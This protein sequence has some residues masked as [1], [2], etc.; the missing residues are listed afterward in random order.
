MGKTL[1]VSKHSKLAPYS[2]GHIFLPCNCK[3]IQNTK[4]KDA[5]YPFS[6]LLH[7]STFSVTF[8]PNAAW[9]VFLRHSDLQ[10]KTFSSKT[11]MGHWGQATLRPATL[12]P[13]HWG[14]ATLRPGDIEARRRWGQATLRPGDFEARYVWVTF[15][16]LNIGLKVATL[17]PMFGLEVATTLRPD[18]VEARYVWVT[19]PKKE[20]AAG[21]ISIVQMFKKCNRFQ[22]GKKSHHGNGNYKL[23]YSDCIL[24]IPF[25]L[26]TNL[27]YKWSKMQ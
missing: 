3:C 1:I 5:K 15:P 9:C 17:R 22:N 21:N 7:P 2:F 12:R 16:N 25:Q 18:D 11:T 27:L 24:R 4:H 26:L 6:W 8:Q 13:R 19:T 14:Q 10:T 20:W 23:F